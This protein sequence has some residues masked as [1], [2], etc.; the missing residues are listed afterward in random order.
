MKGFLRCEADPKAGSGDGRRQLDLRNA[1]LTGL[2]LRCFVELSTR[3]TGPQ[4]QT[5]L[6]P[7]CVTTEYMR[8]K[9]AS[10]TL[11]EQQ[12]VHVAPMC[13]QYVQAVRSDRQAVNLVWFLQPLRIFAKIRID[14]PSRTV[15]LLSLYI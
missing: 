3:A 4:C 12:C 7:C 15:D 10:T 2:T 9:A 13:D 14:S 6:A 1:T 8:L 5:D 11:D